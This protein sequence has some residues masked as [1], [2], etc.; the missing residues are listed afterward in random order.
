MLI[1]LIIFVSIKNI[2]QS[3]SRA[4]LNV[5]SPNVPVVTS[6]FVIPGT[7]NLHSKTQLDPSAS[8]PASRMPVVV[9]LPWSAAQPLIPQ[10]QGN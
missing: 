2:L 4:A 5:P 3:Q 10:G 6:S 8:Q 7:L 9:S 1:S